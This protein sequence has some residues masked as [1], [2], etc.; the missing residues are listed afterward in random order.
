[1]V[2]SID[3]AVTAVLALNDA[4]GAERATLAGGKANVGHAEPAAGV[5][6]LLGLLTVVKKRQAPP[7]ALLRAV[8]SH[9]RE[10]GKNGAKLVLPAQS[11]QM[12]NTTA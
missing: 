7:N 6:G 10:L 9:I 11:T 2:Q 5:V 8:N 3:I 4:I 1:M 12:A